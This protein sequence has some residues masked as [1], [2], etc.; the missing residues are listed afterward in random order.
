MDKNTIFLDEDI[1]IDTDHK[2]DTKDPKKNNKNTAHQT[3]K[4]L[5]Q[6]RKK[7]T[8]PETSNWEKW[9]YTEAWDSVSIFTEE[10]T[11]NLYRQCWMPAT[12]NNKRV[13]RLPIE[14][15]LLMTLCILINDTTNKNVQ[16]KHTI[17]YKTVDSQ[18]E[19]M[20]EAIDEALTPELTLLSDN[21]KDFVPFDEPFIECALYTIDGC[22]FPIL[23]H[24]N[25]WM[26]KTHKMNVYKQHGMRAQILFDNNLGYFRDVIV[27]PC[28][29]N[30]DQKML[31]NSH[32]NQKDALVTEKQSINADGGYTSTKH[33][34]VNKPATQAE[35]KKNPQ[36]KEFNTKF[37]SDRSQIERAF[38]I[39]KNHFAILRNPW[40]RKKELFPLCLRVCMKLMN[41][42][43]SLYGTL[44]Q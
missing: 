21:E 25:S 38:G 39:M 14:E 23:A 13:P 5:Q 28:G 2:Q 30:N 9:A 43:W 17:Y 7:F 33:I 11:Y 44:L 36:L 32:W 27:H 34:N 40:R 31:Q 41:R 16:A 42:Y 3:K 26:Y 22:D 4:A 29:T 6:P 12:S 1:D 24:K 19:R 15:L 18:F 10:D 37:N 35:I 20:L 8:R